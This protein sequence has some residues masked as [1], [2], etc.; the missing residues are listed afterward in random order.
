MQ[1]VVRIQIIYLPLFPLNDL[2][3]PLVVLGEVEVGVAQSTLEQGMVTTGIFIQIP[4]PIS[5]L[6]KRNL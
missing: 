4:V 3:I 1:V 6:G 5:N 2:T